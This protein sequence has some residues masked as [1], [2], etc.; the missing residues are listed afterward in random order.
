L[1]HGRTVVSGPHT[2]AFFSIV[3]DNS[4][5]SV[6]R[7][8]IYRLKRTYWQHSEDSTFCRRLKVKVLSC[9]GVVGATSCGSVPRNIKQISNVKSVKKE[10]PPFCCNGRMQGTVACKSIHQSS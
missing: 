7:H 9:G 3:M 5:P 2:A 6:L 1:V 4:K 10:P 8:S